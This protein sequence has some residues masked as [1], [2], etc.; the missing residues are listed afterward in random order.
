MDVNVTVVLDLGLLCLTKYV[1]NTSIVIPSNIALYHNAGKTILAMRKARQEYKRDNIGTVSM[2]SYPLWVQPNQRVHLSVYLSS[3]KIVHQA[4]NDH[5]TYT[6][7]AG[8]TSCATCSKL[9][10]LSRT[11]E[12]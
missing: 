9:V 12:P 3:Y 6:Q 5:W 11:S 10:P 8:G 7:V 4:M 1:S 2:S